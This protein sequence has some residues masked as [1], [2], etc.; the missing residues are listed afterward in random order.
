MTTRRYFAYGSNIDEAQMVFRCPKS[1]L[2][3]LSCVSGYRFFINERGVASIEKS[4]NHVVYGVLWEIG[5]EDEES[6]DRYEGVANGLYDK[7]T[8]QVGYRDSAAVDA[9]VYIASSSKRGKA[10]PGYMEKIM[11]AAK[12]FSFPAQTIEELKSCLTDEQ[13]T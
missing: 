1:K 2:I 12:R 3:G 11:L 13:S 6:L 8:I 7:L 5:K 4:L 9:L 10:R